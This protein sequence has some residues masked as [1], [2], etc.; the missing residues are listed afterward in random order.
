MRA[1][2]I[3]EPGKAEIVEVPEP[4]P[5]A[6]QVVV[7]VEAVT[8]CPQWDMHIMGGE[9]MFPGQ[10]LTYPYSP[11]QPGHEAVGR[12]VA[13]ADGAGDADNGVGVRVGDR[14]AVWRDQ[15]HSQPGCYAERVARN[16]GDVLV[17]PEDI[18]ATRLSALEL[19][20]CVRVS[21]ELLERMDAV[22]VERFGVSGLGPSG[23]VAAQMAKAGGAAQ[24][25]GYDLSA[26]RREVSKAWGVDEALDPRE[27]SVVD[28]PADAAALDASIDCVGAPSSVQFLMDRTRNAVA[29]FGVLREP[30]QFGWRH[31]A[32]L[33]LL[34][35]R[36]HHRGAAEAA[37]AMIL[38]GSVDLRPLV[39]TT[40]PLDRYTEGVE[41]LR[42]QKA[43]KVCF[44]P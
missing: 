8:T 3:I 12:I 30:V 36:P 37:L 32:G 15:D 28:D 25:V 40:L 41:L 13:V 5:R 1:L 21:F 17:V 18:E 31:W 6:G 42:S 10:E 19:A 22:R 29:L 33:T 39:S 7:E 4:E 14:V 24:V 26:D 11:G 35:Y 34:G 2:Q 38:E 27:C 23:L 9:P 43:V 16:A 20:M 44:T